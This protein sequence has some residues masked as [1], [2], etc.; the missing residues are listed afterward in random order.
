M[1]DFATRL[2]ELRKERGLTQKELAETF[3]LAQTTIANYE[4]K[5]RFPDERLLHRFADFF[6]L[7]LDFLMGRG[8]VRQGPRDYPR[9]SVAA[10]ISDSA[11]ITE[12]ASRYIE[13]LRTEGLAAGLELIQAA[14]RDGMDTRRIYLEILEPA[15]KEVGRLWARGRLSVAEEHAISQA[16]ERIMSR[17]LPLNVQGE[18]T[19]RELTCLVLAV[20]SE[21]HLIGPRMVSDFFRMDGWN[22]RFLGGNLSIRHVLETM[23]RQ[24]PRLLA[25]SVTIAANL[26]EASD[27]ISAVRVEEALR[28]TRIIAG[29][30]ALQASPTFWRDIG[31]DGT[32][33]NAESAIT[34][35]NGL[36][37]R[38]SK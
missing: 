31:A 16:T 17:I 18:T 9:E 30:Q 38:I 32:G 7:S 3:G 14:S 4:K 19:S 28:A 11:V 2:K 21:Q 29:G 23:T 33:E 20:S 22:V 25:V 35:A 37:G 27:L 13:T 1:N 24:P 6:N 10:T 26:S 34:T 15:L 12:T 36:V 5:L 8:D